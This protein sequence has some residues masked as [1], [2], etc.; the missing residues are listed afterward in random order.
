MYKP[1]LNTQLAF[2]DFDQPM[3]LSMNPENRW[4]KKS[5]HHS[6]VRT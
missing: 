3:G 4:I 1:Q 5:G 2:E 6:L